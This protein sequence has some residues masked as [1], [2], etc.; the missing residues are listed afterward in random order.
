MEVLDEFSK[1]LLVFPVLECIMLTTPPFLQNWH[2]PNAFRAALE[3]RLNHLRTLK[4][5]TGS[6]DLPFTVLENCKC[7]HRH[8]TICSPNP[9]STLEDYEVWYSTCGD[10]IGCSELLT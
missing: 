7:P 2:W 4:D 1:T 9:R 6:K 5:L 8:L 10:L 3:D